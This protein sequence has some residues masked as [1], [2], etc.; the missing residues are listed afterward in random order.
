MSQIRVCHVAHM[1]IL[2]MCDV[3]DMTQGLRTG[4]LGEA[5]EEILWNIKNVFSTE[6]IFN[7]CSRFRGMCVT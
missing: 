6:K 5:R 1:M 3:C 2:V 7:I 4:D